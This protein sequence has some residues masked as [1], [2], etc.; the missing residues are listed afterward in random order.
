MAIKKLPWSS[1]IRALVEES[2]EVSTKSAG[3][4]ERGKINRVV[5][6]QQSRALEGMLGPQEC[7]CV[8]WMRGWDSA[9]AP[10]EG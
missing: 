6:N 5:W 9:G 3:C 4:V 1:L 7:E 10:P 8:W 2:K